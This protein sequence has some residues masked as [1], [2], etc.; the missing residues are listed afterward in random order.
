MNPFLS[1]LI[2]APLLFSLIILVGCLYL[3]FTVGPRKDFIAGF[4]LSIVF[5]GFL[6]KLFKKT[7]S[8]KGAL[9][10][11]P[12]LE[13]IS[14]EQKRSLT[15]QDVFVT[16]VVLVG[17]GF[18][19]VGYD[20][21]KGLL[22]VFAFFLGIFLVWS[23]LTIARSKTPITQSV[24]FQVTRATLPRNKKIYFVFVAFVGMGILLS[25]S[26][27]PDWQYISAWDIAGVL[28]FLACSTLWLFLV[29]RRREE[30]DK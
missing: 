23:A 6:L 30:N 29:D 18:L 25:Y 17:A 12:G 1:A 26:Y 11:S 5:S 15:N 2:F 3:I 24:D 16:Y 21:I 27:I 8:P 28:F 4:L 10:E 9:L 22:G 14:E 19:F 7:L 13:D 20:T